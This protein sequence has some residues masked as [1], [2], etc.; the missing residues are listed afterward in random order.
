MIWPLDWP[1]PVDECTLKTYSIV[2]L[3]NACRFQG[4]IGAEHAGSNGWQSYT[5]IYIHIHAY[6]HAYTYWCIVSYDV[7]IGVCILHVYAHIHNYRYVYSSIH[8]YMY[9]YVC[10]C[11]YNSEM[12]CKMPKYKKQYMQVYSCIC[13]YMYVNICICMNMQLYVWVCLRTHLTRHF[14][15]VSGLVSNWCAHWTW[16][17]AGGGHDSC[18]RL[19][20]SCQ[21]WAARGWAK[22]RCQQADLRHTP[23]VRW[24]RLSQF[25]Y[26]PTKTK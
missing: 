16:K 20:E 10:I 19:E 1:K 9:V 4:S 26:C 13:M 3:C 6:I 11:M 18:L 7:R 15:S 17:L 14:F 22:E 24:S 12:D 25:N 21:S 2:S 8:M 23:S 5:C